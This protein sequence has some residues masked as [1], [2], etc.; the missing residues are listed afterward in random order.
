MN[1]LQMQ[2]KHKSP[3]MVHLIMKFFWLKLFD[4]ICLKFIIF[5]EFPNAHMYTL[6]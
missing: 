2:K 3:K 6:Y 4:K 1:L 5:E